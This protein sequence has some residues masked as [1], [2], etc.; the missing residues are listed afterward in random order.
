ML[1]DSDHKKS[2]TSGHGSKKSF[3]PCRSNEVKGTP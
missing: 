3:L 2:K 1:A